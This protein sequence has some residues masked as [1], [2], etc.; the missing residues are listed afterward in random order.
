MITFL[1]VLFISDQS[2]DPAYLVLEAVQLSLGTGRVCTCAVCSIV[3]IPA[4]V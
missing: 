1:V 3:V 4:C 2:H